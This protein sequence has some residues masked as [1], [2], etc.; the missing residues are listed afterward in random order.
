MCLTPD[1]VLLN[2][3]PGLLSSVAGGEQRLQ[4][5]PGSAG[6]LSVS[7]PGPWERLGSGL[8]LEEALPALPNPPNPSGCDPSHPLSLLRSSAG[9]EMTLVLLS[10]AGHQSW[11]ASGLPPCPCTIPARETSFRQKIWPSVSLCWLS[12]TQGRG[13]GRE[14]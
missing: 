8:H 7:W 13:R 4:S 11:G 12:L 5:R 6:C 1:T 9:F 14:G 2:R 10:P 3:P